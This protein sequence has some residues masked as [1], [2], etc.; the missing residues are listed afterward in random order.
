MHIKKNM[1]VYMA[2]LYDV[3]IKNTLQTIFCHQKNDL[4]DKKVYIKKNTQKK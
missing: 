4:Y 3:N 1:L 2:V